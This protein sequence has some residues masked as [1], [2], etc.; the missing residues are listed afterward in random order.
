MEF[1]IGTQFRECRHKG[2]SRVCTVTDIL[3]T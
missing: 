3:K 2:Y 1:P